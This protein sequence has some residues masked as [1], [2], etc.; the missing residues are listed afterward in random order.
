MNTNNQDK[1]IHVV[2]GGTNQLPLVNKIK[3]MGYKVLVTDMYENPPCKKDADFFEQINTTDKEATLKS[4]LKHNIY[5]II[6]DQTDVAVPTVAFIS[7]SLNLPSIGYDTALLF[8]NK[9][10]MREKLKTRLPTYIP[11]FQYFLT[12]SDCID[13]Y[14]KN[15]D[16]KLIV[17][18]VNSQGSKGV[19]ILKDSNYREA[20]SVSFL[21]SKNRGVLVEHFIGGHEFSVEAYTE[22]G[23]TYDLAITK[24]YHYIENDCIDEKNTYLGDVSAEIEKILF[25]ANRKIIKA[26]GLPFGISHAEYKVENGKVYLMEIAAR[27][28]GG[29]IS[30]YIIPFLTDFD[31]LQALINHILDIPNE[32]KIN[33]YKRRY[34][35]LKFFNF[36]KGKIKKIYINS[37]ATKDL[38]FF[39][40]DIKPGET[41]NPIRD[42]RDRPGYFIVHGFDRNEVIRK[43][44]LVESS[45]QVEYE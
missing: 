18:P 42:S 11:E 3:K 4:A 31:P 9:Y 40:L 17:K 7:D 27:G 34:A 23:S 6:T 2:G 22:N 16:R 1:I 24:K 45:V 13:F 41:I 14:E 44:K 38:L 8:T 37:D 33:D 28:A 39:T 36:K 25:D 21:E 26:L 19:F 5:R 15:R 43:E 35:I 10:M 32:I 20:I 29:S 30:S 12:V